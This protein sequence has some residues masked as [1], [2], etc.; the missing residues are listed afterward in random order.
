VTGVLEH[1]G[2]LLVV[3]QRLGLLAP[4]H[5]RQLRPAER[6]VEEQHVAAELRARDQRV[7]EA[8]VVARHQP[9]AVALAQPGVRQRVGERVGARL[10]L[11]E[12]E[13]PQLVDDR[14][15]VRIARGG[16]RVAGGRRRPPAQHRVGEAEQAVRA[17]GADDARLG[18]RLE[19]EELG[20]DLAPERHRGRS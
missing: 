15:L 2:E 14:R 19:R 3:E 17:R 13:R 6:R 4:D 18:E 12:R 16:H 9:D 11:P 5:V 1:L 8:A 7:D 20:G 10:D